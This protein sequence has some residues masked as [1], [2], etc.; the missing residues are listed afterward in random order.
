MM[1]S[2]RS[3]RVAATVLT[4][5]SLAACSSKKD[6]ATPPLPPH[7]RVTWTVDGNNVTA[8]KYSEIHVGQ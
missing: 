5:S 6:D 8:G 2:F 4:F 1:F 7:Q 3:F